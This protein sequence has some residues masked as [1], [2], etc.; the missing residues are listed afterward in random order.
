MK[1]SKSSYKRGMG[2]EVL[3]CREV[4]EIF[5]E[6]ECQIRFGCIVCIKG[7][8]S[9]VNSEKLFHFKG[10]VLLTFKFCLSVFILNP[11]QN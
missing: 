5:E 4:G 7:R 11:L 6:N 1:N 8:Q 10:G 3:I 2:G 9:K